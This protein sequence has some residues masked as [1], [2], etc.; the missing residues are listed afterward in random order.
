[1]EDCQLLQGGVN[2]FRL[3]YQRIRGFALL[4][5]EFWS[6]SIDIQCAHNAHGS[7]VKCIELVLRKRYEAEWAYSVQI[8]GTRVTHVYNMSC[9]RQGNEHNQRGL[10]QVVQKVPVP[11]L[12]PSRASVLVAQTSPWQRNN[13]V[14]KGTYL[15]AAGRWV[16]KIKWISPNPVKFSS[17][18]QWVFRIK[19]SPWIWICVL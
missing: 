13:L 6:S 11:Y 3:N 16:T 19:F 5:D 9:K 8:E 15:H 7:A 14:S 17:Y 10:A 2:N 18:Q 1:M 4:S 12:C